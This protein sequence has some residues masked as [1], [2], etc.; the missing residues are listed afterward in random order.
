MAENDAHP[1]AHADIIDDE[2]ARTYA[3]FI[4]LMKYSA[5]TSVAILILLAF[6]WG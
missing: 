4:K 5:A 3:M 1:A 2:H 6:L